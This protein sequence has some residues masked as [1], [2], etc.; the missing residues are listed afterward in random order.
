MRGEGSVR[1]LFEV[2]SAA[3]AAVVLWLAAI[4]VVPMAK[5]I[6]EIA[7][8]PP[9]YAQEM[10][11]YLDENVPVDAV[12]ETWDPEMG[13]LTDHNY[14]YPPNALLALAVQQVY[15]GGE[16]VREHYHFVQT[17]RP[18][19]LLAGV[20]SKW[21]GVYPLDDLAGEYRLVRTFGTYDLYERV[22]SD[23]DVGG[24]RNRDSRR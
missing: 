16:P 4:I 19:Y 18:Q 14:H 12:V 6:S 2:R 22:R 11:A 7:A 5:T 1:S 21:T 3:R 8:P 10:S 13:F 17:E 9:A 15:F 24:F 20:F 23:A